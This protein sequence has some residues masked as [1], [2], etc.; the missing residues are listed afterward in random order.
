[1]AYDTGDRGKNM[2]VSGA[3]GIGI[4]SITVNGYIYGAGEV[5]AAM[6]ALLFDI[7]SRIDRLEKSSSQG[8][9]VKP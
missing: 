1:M 7:M 9:E 8:K 2:M 4:S 6:I 5:S 3:D